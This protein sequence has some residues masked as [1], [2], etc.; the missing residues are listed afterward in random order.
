[1]NVVYPDSVKVW[2]YLAGVWTDLTSYV[3]GDITGGW[4]I[5]GNGPLDRLA[6]TG[7]MDILLNN[8]SLQFIPGDAGALAGWK[9]G[10]PVKLEVTYEGETYV[11]FKGVIEAIKPQPGVYGYLRVPVTIVDWLDYSARHPVVNPGIL[12]NQRGDDVIRTTLGLIPIQ[13]AEKALD[14]GASVFPTSFDTVTSHT[15]AYSEL[16]KVAFSEPGYIYL[17][18]GAISGEMLVFESG[19]K[20][21]GLRTLTQFP[22][23]VSE[24]GFLLKEDGGY[25]L[26]EDAGKIILNQPADG[27]V[28]DNTMSG[29]ETE[30]GERVLNYFTVYA[31]PRKIDTSAQV[32]FKLNA[33]IG[34]GSGKTIQI[35]G[36]YADPAG[37]LPISGQ[38]MITPVA[39]TD[40]QMWT[41]KDGTGT[42]ITSDLVLVSKPYGT[43][44]FTHKVKN[45]NASPGWITKY[46]PRGYGIYKYNPIEHA[47]SDDESIAEFG[48]QTESMDQKYQTSLARGS[49]VAEASVEWDRKP[50]TVLNKLHFIANRSPALMMAFLN[51]DCGDLIRVKED[52]RDIDAY[53]YIQGVDKF[54]IKPG[55]F[56]AYSWIMKEALSLKL[57]LSMIAVEFTPSPAQDAVDFGVLP[58]VYSDSTPE[59]ISI[60]AWIYSHALGEPFGKILVFSPLVGG[61]QFNRIWDAGTHYAIGIY[62]NIFNASAGQW[63]TTTYP[64]V[65]NTWYHVVVTFDI[66]SPS[67]DPTFYIN[68]TALATNEITTPAGTKLSKENLP[69]VIGNQKDS[70]V[71]YDFSINGKMMDVRI[72]HRILSA[73]EV[74]TLYNGGTQDETL[75]TDGLVFQTFCV[76]TKELVDFVDVTLGE[77]D[78]VLDNIY[79]VVGTPHGSPIGRA[80]P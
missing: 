60:S 22:K 32:L 76:R 21:N 10:I 57:G 37:G 12:S 70:A 19:K 79:G 75:V 72:Y 7:T 9:K 48:H 31:N 17:R 56:I 1:M 58:D 30:Y 64:M 78:N 42:D 54:T 8:E 46:D 62:G 23:P 47:A 63:Q 53:Y 74:T 4:G 6:R 11:R 52:T 80:M 5:D 41:N 29:I 45:N 68:G 14:V 73:A 39:T 44:G 15:K 59:T 3:I 71:D 34:I 67:N 2:A 69:L 16:G 20:R 24:S 18:K 33:P 27:Y 40:Y 55:G 35:K 43:E 65:I 77:A 13:P 26:K 51:G 61:L 38:D 49:I 28:A 66:S 36:S 25:L 50:R